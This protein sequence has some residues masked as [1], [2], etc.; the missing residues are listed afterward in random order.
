MH[1]SGLLLNGLVAKKKHDDSDSDGDGVSFDNEDAAVKYVTPKTREGSVCMF[2]GLNLEPPMLFEEKNSLHS[3][4]DGTTADAIVT[5]MTFTYTY[6]LYDGQSIFTDSH[7]EQ[8]SN[9][10]FDYVILSLNDVRNINVDTGEHVSLD[11]VYF[12]HLIIDPLP[13]LG[14]ETL[15][16]SKPSNPLIKFPNG[17]GMHSVISEQIPSININAHLLSN[18]NLEPT[19]GSIALAHKQCNECYYGANKGSD[20]TTAT[21]G[22]FKCCG[23]SPACTTATSDDYCHCTIKNKSSRTKT[24]YRIEVDMTI[25]REIDKF[26]RVDMWTVTAPACHVNQKGTS[27]FEKLS[28]DNFCYHN[29]LLPYFGGASL[30]HKID[31]QNDDDPLVETKMN[32][33]AP[34][35]GLIV[36]GLGHLHTGGVSATLRINGKEVCTTGTTY[37]S[38]TNEKTNARNEQNHLIA[39]GSCYHTAIYN[40]GGVRFKEG[41]VITAESIYNGSINDDR[42]VGHGAAGEHKNVMSYFVLGVIFDGNSDWLT[43]KR[44]TKKLFNNFVN[45]AGL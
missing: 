32:V 36:H 22:T 44:N 19:D 13:M 38:N 42:F 28:P 18:K 37:G 30:F 6:E 34:A 20:C 26:K 43:E 2:C 3:F 14:A 29:T 1:R 9:F 10:D 17:Y 4:D 12:H 35:S 24:K 7:H 41:D 31:L 39:I 23:D 27:I 16:G 21:S 8:V 11:E 5:P 25:S 15:Y 33:I 40:D 45:T